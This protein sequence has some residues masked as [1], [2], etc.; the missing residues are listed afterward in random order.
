MSGNTR[1]SLIGLFVGI[2]STVII[3][4]ILESVLGWAGISTALWAL[5]IG[6]ILLLVLALAQKW[7]PLQT[8]IA[9]GTTL[10][11]AVTGLASLFII[12]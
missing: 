3:R 10:I 2:L 9:L 1:P 8:I 7:E 6:V 5:F 4:E 11:G 12:F